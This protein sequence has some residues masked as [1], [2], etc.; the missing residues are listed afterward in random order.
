MRNFRLP[1]AVAPRW[2]G[3]GA[4]GG[5]NRSIAIIVSRCK[6]KMGKVLGPEGG[7]APARLRG[8]GWPAR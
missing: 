6:L 8:L 3:K 5:K 7:D 2:Q 1:T 4:G